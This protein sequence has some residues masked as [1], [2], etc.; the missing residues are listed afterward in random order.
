M[1]TQ[2]TIAFIL[3]AIVV[4]LAYWRG[5]L[6]QSGAAGA[7]LIG[8]LTFGIGGWQWGVLL[9]LF[10]VTSSLLSHF[11]EAEKKAAAEKFDKGHRR[12][13]GQVIANGGLGACIA[14][15]SAFAPGPSAAWF[16]L[17][18]GVM[19]TVTA[20]TWA[21]ELGTLSKRQP[22]LITTGRMVEVGTSG[23][24]SPLGTVVSLLGGLLIGLT[25]GLITEYSIV[26]TTMA[27]A[28]AGLLGS[29]V[30]S[31]LGATVQRIY[32]TDVRHKETEKKY[33]N[34]GTPNRVLRGWAWMSN[35]M[36]NLLSSIGGG[37]T[38]VTLTAL[39][40]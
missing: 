18:L 37:I 25:A 23:G 3:S 7:L 39:F 21:T 15:I 33:E 1:I 30:D 20:D 34:D 6:S 9:V 19:A 28:I 35:D 11:K 16:F 29:L 5:S 8:T 4:A 40:S 14:T 24:I 22:R 26:V 36:V 12:D 27:G 31:L 2:L 13:I 17:F 38:A 10:F 32:Y